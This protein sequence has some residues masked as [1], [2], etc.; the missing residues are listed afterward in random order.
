MGY[1]RLKGVNGS[2]YLWDCWN[3]TYHWGRNTGSTPTNQKL[4]KRTADGIESLAYDFSALDDDNFTND[5]IVHQIIAF[6][7]VLFVDLR[8]AAS[9]HFLY[10]TTDMTG[11][12]G[13][14]ESAK[15]GEYGGTHYANVSILGTR[16]LCEATIDGAKVHLYGDYNTRAE[17][18]GAEDGTVAV[19]KSTDDGATWSVVV[20]WNGSASFNNVNHC[21]LVTQNPA[22]TQI[23]IGLG[24]NTNSGILYWDGTTDISGLNDTTPTG[25]RATGS[26]YYFLHG[27]KK[28]QTTDVIFLPD[29]D[30]LNPA[31]NLNTSGVD[32][33]AQGVWRFSSTLSHY[34]RVSD[35]NA[36][37]AHHNLYWGA[38][39]CGYHFACEIIN[40]SATGKELL[41]SYIY[42]SAN[43][44]PNQWDVVAKIILDNNFV[45]GGPSGFYVANNQL[46][47]AWNDFAGRG[48]WTYF[49]EL[50]GE[51]KYNDQRGNL[52]AEVIAPLAWVSPS[53]TDST[54]GN[55][56]F[57]PDE[58]WASVKY[59]CTPNNF[60]QGGCIMVAAGEYLS[61]QI[62]PGFSTIGK[63]G[64]TF[65]TTFV[66]PTV[67]KG[68]GHATTRMALDS[69]SS[70]TTFILIDADGTADGNSNYPGDEP[71]RFMDIHVDSDKAS[72]VILDTDS[73]DNAYFDA[74]GARFGDENVSQSRTIRYNGA[75]E[76]PLGHCIVEK[77]SAGQPLLV[78]RAGGK[79]ITLG[80]VVKGGEYSGRCGVASGQLRARGTIFT[81]YTTAALNHF[82]SCNE[83]VDA[84]GC[85]GDGDSATA[86]IQQAA[87]TNA[88]A[89]HNVTAEDTFA[90]TITAS[91]PDAEI[92]ADET[93]ADVI[94]DIANGDYTPLKELEGGHGRLRYDINGEL[95]KQPNQVGPEEYQPGKRPDATRV[96]A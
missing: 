11:E 48:D 30:A 5:A 35:A 14:T 66:V 67:I 94:T 63:S 12:S 70:D 13:W 50:D 68:E 87:T 61:D 75:Q 7:G 8:N 79:I 74:Y 19:Y 82:S 9:K 59:A 95:C 17:T 27:N 25:G 26:G 56:G 16:G 90:A 23:L 47:I 44:D 73:N 1:P 20:Q 96:D 37:F 32:D 62:N 52:V 78:N 38:S 91:H 72:A 88:L 93:P 21:H 42:A 29:G 28:Y 24:D 22:T 84:V 53:G 39:L 64:L 51:I 92:Y 77:D 49:Y 31:D 10:R 40:P 43:G 33:G 57:L 55:T 65:G 71:V 3:G 58:P 4:Y 45:G 80:G 34:G 46:V 36:Q 2:A 76:V 41:Q 15:I 83:E 89:H 81:G 18:S 86:F 54:S 69:E 60:P 85:I 6:A